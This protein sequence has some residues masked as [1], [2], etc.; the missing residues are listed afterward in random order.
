ME[1]GGQDEVRER[2]AVNNMREG[3]EVFVGASGLE[4]AGIGQAMGGKM[5]LGMRRAV[6]EMRRTRWEKW[7]KSGMYGTIVQARLDEQEDGIMGA[8]W[9]EIE[10]SEKRVLERNMR[11]YVMI[12]SREPGQFFWEKS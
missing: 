8:K 4:E 5:G 2:W 12:D 9:M 1:S 7:L 3:G 10:R 11:R 6:A